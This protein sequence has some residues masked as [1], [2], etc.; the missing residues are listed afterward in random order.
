MLEYNKLFGDQ[1]ERL[2]GKTRFEYAVVP[3]FSFVQPGV[4]LNKESDSTHD[5]LLLG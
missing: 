3:G 2:D 4:G 5:E 1:K